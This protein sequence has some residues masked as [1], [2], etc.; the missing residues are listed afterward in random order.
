MPEEFYRRPDNLDLLLAGSER[1]LSLF[2][3][4]RPAVPEDRIL[5]APYLTAALRRLAD[6]AR[7]SPEALLGAGEV[8]P[9]EV[10]YDDLRLLLKGFQEEQADPIDPT[11][12]QA[13]QSLQDALEAWEFDGDA[14]QATTLSSL[15]PGQMPAFGGWYIQPEI[16][17]EI[18]QALTTY[19][20][21][22]FAGFT[23][24]AGNLAAVVWP[25]RSVLSPATALPQS[26]RCW[27]EAPPAWA[28]D[29]KQVAKAVLESGGGQLASACLGQ[30]NYTQF[31][32]REPEVVTLY[33]PSMPAGDG[34][35][36]VVGEPL[37]GMAAD[38]AKPRSTYH[39]RFQQWHYDWPVAGG[40]LTV[41]LS[42]Q[43]GRSSITNSFW[44]ISAGRDFEPLPVCPKG[45]SPW[46]ARPCAM[47]RRAQT[48]PATP[49][50]PWNYTYLPEANS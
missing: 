8:P 26:V 34:L 35:N 33:A 18:R 12:E 41:H 39:V 29:A 20:S 1:R 31:F 24:L 16:L 11:V 47:L 43:D 15:S 21:E 45:P 36:E 5:A 44:P 19:E 22:I 46:L 49:T 37:A 48:K 9:T 10:T 2:G 14:L 40:Q 30:P 28:A 25:F 3:V 17:P 6:L 32:P 4:E 23:D 38:E 42:Q 7:I 50:G 27:A 13:L